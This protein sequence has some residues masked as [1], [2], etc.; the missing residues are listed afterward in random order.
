M[1][2]ENED[3]SKAFFIESFSESEKAVTVFCELFPMKAQGR[4]DLHEIYIST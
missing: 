3:V 2:K 4:F 1:S